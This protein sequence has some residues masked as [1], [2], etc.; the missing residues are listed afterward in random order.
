MD[1]GGRGG[2][3]RGVELAQ[4]G[5]HLQACVQ[6][7]QARDVRGPAHQAGIFQAEWNIAPD[8]GE[9]ARECDDIHAGAQV[10]TGFAGDFGRTSQ[11]C[12]QSAVGIEPLCGRLRAYLIDSWNVVGAVAHQ[13]QVVDDLFRIDVEFCLDPR[14][15]QHRVVH[16]VD[17]GDALIDQLRHV[18]IAGRD[19]H[20]FAGLG[21]AGGKRANNVV[22]LDSGEPQQRQAHAGHRLQ[23][24]FD[25]RAQII[26]HR[27]P[28]GLVLGEE[29]IAE[30]LA[31]R[32]ENYGHG[33]AGVVAQ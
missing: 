9:L 25:L 24:R 18:F 17:Q 7:T 19:Q 1:P 29:L 8:R 10:V 31:R 16:G 14:P 26:G 15:V 6:F 28:V 11:Q 4:K 3:N 30:G 20:L 23:E 22:R 5:T 27:W 33:R 21:R 12:V 32:V 2:R 13:G